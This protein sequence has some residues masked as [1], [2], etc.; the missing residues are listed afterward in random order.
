MQRRSASRAQREKDNREAESML[1][2][3]G[4][5]G[6]T[7]WERAL[8]Y[9]NFGFTRPNGSDL[10]RMKGLLFSAKSKN[11]PV[12]SQNWHSHDAYS[13]VTWSQLILQSQWHSC[14]LQKC[15]CHDLYLNQLCNNQTSCMY[16]Y[17]QHSCHTAGRDTF[18]ELMMQ[19]LLGAKLLMHCPFENCCMS[20]KCASNIR[21][22]H[23][24]TFKSS[25]WHSSLLWHSINSCKPTQVSCQKTILGSYEDKAA[26]VCRLQSFKI[27]LHLGTNWMIGVA[28]F[29]LE[30]KY[31]LHHTH[32]TTCR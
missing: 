24:Q 8:D 12:K 26:I 11:V 32:G 7:E 30:V 13:N 21:H 29:R 1:T 31:K 27:E 28:N 22:N 10:S 25:I 3:A 2:V 5:K 9:V 18:G 6:D 14:V 20:W 15:A 19:C 4:P 17:V 16:L 23:S